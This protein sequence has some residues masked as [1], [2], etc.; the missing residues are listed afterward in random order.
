MLTHKIE[1]KFYIHN[2]DGPRSDACTNASSPFSLSPDDSFLFESLSMVHH[3][4]CLEVSVHAHTNAC[5]LIFFF[6]LSLCF[7]SLLKLA[8]SPSDIH[9]APDDDDDD[10]PTL[11]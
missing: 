10:Y 8:L 4:L 9:Q 6:S 2:I 1:R 11:G 3:P 5:S 7:F